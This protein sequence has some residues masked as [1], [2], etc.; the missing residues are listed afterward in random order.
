MLR[1]DGVDLLGDVDDHLL[2]L[3]EAR[4]Q[5]RRDVGLLLEDE[6]GE[7]RDDFGRREVGEHVFEDE[8]GED[9]LVG[10]VDLAGDFALELHARAVVDEAE[11]FE[12]ENALFVVGEE[13]QVL[14]GH[15]LPEL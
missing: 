7:E 8:L 12:H 5:R 11:V 9:E 6:G 4:R 2:A 15:E 10:A 3:G 13:L 1:L 14:V